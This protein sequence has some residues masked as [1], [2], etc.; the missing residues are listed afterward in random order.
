[1]TVTE[2]ELGG[3]VVVVPEKLILQRSHSLHGSVAASIEN[4]RNELAGVNLEDATRPLSSSGILDTPIGIADIPTA[5]AFAFAFG[6]DGV[7][8]RGGRPIPEAIE[9]MRILNGENEWGI[10]M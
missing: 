7:L 5:D 6:I 10:K 2:R 9:A 8:I 3:P 4:A 1:M